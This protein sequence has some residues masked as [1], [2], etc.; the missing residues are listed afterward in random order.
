[1]DCE[2]VMTKESM[3]KLCRELKLYSNCPELNDVI[4]LHQK[5]IRKIQAL[6]E[7]IGLRTIY[8]ECNAISKLEGL[9]PL[10]NLQCLY[11]NQN[12]ISQIEGLETLQQLEILDLADNQIKK[13]TGLSCLP[14]LRQLNLSGNFI[15]HESDVIHLLD[16]KSLKSLDVSN[17]RIDNEKAL[18]ALR[19][20]PL[21]LLRL[22]SNKILS[23][24]CNYRKMTVATMSTLVYLDES[25]IFENERRLAMAWMVGG[26]D[27]ER[28][29][30]LT[31]A[32]EEA[33]T[34]DHHRKEFEDIKIKAK[35]ELA[36][37]YL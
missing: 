27:A 8:F 9:A 16:C 21:N 7:Y 15:C 4:H 32:N 14:C 2:F 36:E 33:A 10:I 26:I 22:M 11:L 1:M 5:G 28:N 3:K 29:M 13:V 23:I 35:R 20:I 19:S 25:P 24:T 6:E 34:R 37:K 18:E 30:R 31:I 12:C 17:N